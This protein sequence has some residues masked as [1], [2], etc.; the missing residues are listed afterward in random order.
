[1][2]TDQ[3]R[4]LDPA[5]HSRMVLPVDENP[6]AAVQRM[7]DLDLDNAWI[8]QSLGA[9]HVEIK[10]Y[11]QTISRN[12]WFMLATIAVNT[13]LVLMLAALAWTANF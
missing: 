2:P 12:Q 7:T 4:K 13:V 8:R 10:K 1:M 11:Q 9:I 3:E 5:R 6:S